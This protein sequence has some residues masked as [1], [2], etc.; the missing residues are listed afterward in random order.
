MKYG[1]SREIGKRSVAL[2]MVLSL[3]IAV[4]GCAESGSKAPVE[5]QVT[6]EMPPAATDKLVIYQSPYYTSQ[7]YDFVIPM[8][9]AKYPDVEVEIR[10]FG[11]MSGSIEDL[12]LMENYRTVLQTEMMAGSGPDVV[13]WCNDPGPF[14]SDNFEDL[15]KVMGA[16]TF[17]NLDNFIA[18]D[19]DFHMSDYNEAV[20]DSG[21]YRGKRQFVPLCYGVNTLMTSQEFMDEEGI[22]L[23]RQP[24]FEELCTYVNQYCAKYQDD[25]DRWPFYIP[26]KNESLCAF[27]YPFNGLE[28]LDYEQEQ[29]KLDSDAFRQTME[30]YR[31]IHPSV[32]TRTTGGHD[33]PRK[34]YPQL[35]DE[36]A[37]LFM[38]SQYVSLYMATMTYGGLMSYGET[39]LIFGFPNVNGGKSAA[40]AKTCAAIPQNAQNKTNAYHFIKIL[41]SETVQSDHLLTYSAM[42]LPVHHQSRRTKLQSE[43]Q[44]RADR[45]GLSAQLSVTPVSDEQLEQIYQ[46]FTDVEGVK[47]Y[48]VTLSHMVW[49][50]MLPYFDGTTGYEE[51]VKNLENELKLYVAE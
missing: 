19:E 27:L 6:L 48:S 47:N 33:F 28:I 39:P 20:M 37:V 29:I 36:R 40:Y 5:Y 21:I 45:Y 22:S 26:D 13:L 24:T 16:D 49:E 10:D 12:E 4:T 50:A 51:C 15:Y 2:L 7:L 17:Y 30:A 11:R 38:T 31:T 42:D 41:L 46:V 1:S 18:Q 8:F 9:K 35:V 3:L 34:P 14:L 43:L 32:Y 23:S 25:E 44:L